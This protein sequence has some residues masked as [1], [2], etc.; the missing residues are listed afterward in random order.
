MT[1][2][3]IEPYFKGKRITVMG[4]GLLGR[5]L[6]VIQF[7]Y[8]MGA[9]LTVTDLKTAEQLAPSVKKLQKFPG[10]K[11]VL[12]EHR[13]ED[14]TN[15]DML[16]RAPN[17]PLNSPYVAA[18][19]AAGV[20]VEM[21]ASLFTALVP[22]GV[23][24]IGITGTR[25]KTTTTHLIAA[26]LKAARKRVHVGGNIRGGSTLPL[27]LKVKRGD[28]V[29]LEL[30][31]WQLQGFAERQMSPHI[32]VFTSFMDDHVNYYV[33]N[34][35]DTAERAT[36]MARYFED[37]SAI[38][39]FQKPGDF[40]VIHE[41]V[42]YEHL[43]HTKAKMV[44]FSVRTVPK[45]WKLKMAGGHNRENAGAALEVAHVLN[46]SDTI[47][48]KLFESFSGVAGRQELVR[49]VRGVKYI[50]DTTA[51]TPD[52]SMIAMKTLAPKKGK[53]IILIAGGADKKLDYALWGKAVEQYAKAVVLFRGTASEK[54]EAAI[55]DPTVVVAKECASMADALAAARSVAEKGDIVL[56]S[57]AAASFGV[58]THEYDRGDQFVDA[59]NKL[60]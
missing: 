51:T 16:L 57:P 28:Y 46:I 9:E 34:A 3:E 14:F 55:V 42:V 47:S 44:R 15:T 38:F 7:L 43:I 26:L 37:K 48:K 45:S 20:P 52:A 29:V 54:I 11:F 10:I 58:F 12:G 30:D 8:S 35:D 49:I 36:G 2:S 40:C 6:S 17:A 53:R 39:S 60:K 1:H 18:A 21:D 32:S 50:N 23:N 27:L 25:G 4:L 5:S 13:T 56:L 31:S 24:I 41:K 33:Q 22:E 19:K 59:V